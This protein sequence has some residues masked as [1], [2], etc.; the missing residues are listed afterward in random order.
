MTHQ[1]LLTPHWAGAAPAGHAGHARDRLRG[2]D[3]LRP[4]TRR[5]SRLRPLCDHCGLYR[6]PATDRATTARAQ[7]D[8]GRPGAAAAQ[9]LSVHAR[10]HVARH[11]GLLGTVGE[12]R[13]VFL[14]LH[15]GGPRVRAALSDQRDGGP[16]ALCAP[17]PRRSQPRASAHRWG[18]RAASDPHAG[19]RPCPGANP[20]LLA[21]F[22]DYLEGHPSAPDEP[23]AILTSVMAPLGGMA[24]SEA[25]K[26]VDLQAWY[27]RAVADVTDAASV[28]GHAGDP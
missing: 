23:E 12:W 2:Q 13:G 19:R 21:A 5:R 24:S 1:A 15:H 11:G 16:G 17:R 10:Q 26:E 6:V 7:C 27:R 9:H 4:Q 22:L 20:G 3:H 18:G 8:A 14:R 28:P 25:G